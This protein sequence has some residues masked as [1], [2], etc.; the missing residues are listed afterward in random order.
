[1]WEEIPYIAMEY[2]EGED[3]NARLE[4]VVRLPHPQTVRIVSQVAKGLTRAH[5]A[6]IV[7]RDLKP[8][9]IFL[10]KDGDDEVA[11]VLDFGIAKRSQTSLSEAGTKTGSLMGTPFYMSPEQARGVK[12]IDHRSDLFSLAI[13][14]YQ[15]VT[16][17]LPFYS[18]GLGDVLAQI[19]YEPIPVPSQ[20]GLQ[21]PAGFDAWWH[22][23]AA[24]PVEARFQS[25]KDLADS[26]A[27][28]LGIHNT[29][30]IPMLEPRPVQLSSPDVPPSMERIMAPTQLAVPRPV[31]HR[32]I[33]R[34]FVRTFDPTPAP[35]FLRR[36][37]AVM[38]GAGG[39]ALLLAI[40]LVVFGSRKS[41]SGAGQPTAFAQGAVDNAALVGSLPTPAP[42]VQET[43]PPDSPKADD[44]AG[45]ATPVSSAGTPA[46]A[47]P[48]RK[49]KAPK[50]PGPKRD[51]GI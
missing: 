49:G 16:G 37:N 32:T 24:R 15:C 4:R 6:G 23:A 10:A 22:R 12:S 17:K 25:A 43:A 26:L 2:L 5:A 20:Q 8:E 9:N 40:G 13:I 31:E 28:A 18:E 14:A 50:G 11:K 7:H 39:A 36:K 1:V 41:A 38:M 21:V 35:S 47:V 46:S 44:V 48:R 34:P 42:T 27:L 19:M 29:V 30:D 51:Y 33:D 45:R 3:L